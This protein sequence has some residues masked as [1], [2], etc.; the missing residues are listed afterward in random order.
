MKPSIL[1]KKI[2]SLSCISFE[3]KDGIIILIDELMDK[4]YKI[5]SVAYTIC[6]L[7]DGNRSILDI[8][9]ELTKIYGIDV[10]EVQDDVYDFYKFLKKNKLIIMKGTLCYKVILFYQYCIR[11]N[12][13]NEVK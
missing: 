3:E 11:I 2:D 13:I 10:K 7:I 8:C 12:S 9:D 4:R 1:R 5:N 6:Q